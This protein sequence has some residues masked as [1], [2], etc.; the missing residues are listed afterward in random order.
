MSLPLVMLMVPVVIDIKLFKMIRSVN[1]QHPPECHVLDQ[2]PPLVESLFSPSEA[3]K[4]ESEGSSM[5]VGWL[6]T[7]K[8]EGRNYNMLWLILKEL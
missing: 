5:W 6:C 4:S 7:A 8:G 1:R 3:H 2:V